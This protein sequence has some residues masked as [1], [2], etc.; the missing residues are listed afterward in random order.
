MYKDNR[1]VENDSAAL[2]S[3]QEIAD[4]RAEMKSNDDARVKFDTDQ[5]VK[6]GSEQSS[7]QVS[8]FLYFLIR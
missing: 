1:A 2:E 7:R 3:S 8:P 6:E 5:E 4:C